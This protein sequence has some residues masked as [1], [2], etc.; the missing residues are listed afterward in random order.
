MREPRGIPTG[1][2][3]ATGTRSEANVELAPK[4]L[5]ERRRQGMESVDAGDVSVVDIRGKKTWR[6]KN[7]DPAVVRA[8][9]SL[10]KDGM[11][12]LNAFSQRPVELGANAKDMLT[13][14]QVRTDPR[15]TSDEQY[16]DDRTADVEKVMHCDLPN[17]PQV[18]VNDDGGGPYL[19][20]ELGG[21]RVGRDIAYINAP[22]NSGPGQAFQWTICRG[23]GEEIVNLGVDANA[24][25]VSVSTALLRNGFNKGTFGEK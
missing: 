13:A 7:V 9:K 19:Q 17:A 21:Q 22:D 5:T 2:Q 15:W 18:V 11:L 10:D 6:F 20:M 8:V 1:G 25:P 12:N 16:I 23:D 4:R 24:H 3:F 14:D